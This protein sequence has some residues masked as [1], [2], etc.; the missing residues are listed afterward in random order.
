MDAKTAVKYAKEYVA[1]MFSEE[2]ARDI[3]LEEVEYDHEQNAWRVTIGFTRAWDE[4]RSAIAALSAGSVK[5]TY[6][7]L[8]V[9]DPDGVVLSVHNRDLMLPMK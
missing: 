4:P 5:R 3:G 1:D 7:V 9:N 6:K 2:G 8:T